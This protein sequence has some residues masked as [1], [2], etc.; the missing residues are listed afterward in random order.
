MVLVSVVRHRSCGF[1]VR[2]TGA[3]LPTVPAFRIAV[4][5]SG[6]SAVRVTG[7]RYCRCTAEN[8]RVDVVLMVTGGVGMAAVISWCDVEAVNIEAANVEAVNAEAV[9]VSL[10]CS[11]PPPP[12]RGDRDFLSPLI[13]I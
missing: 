3:G 5:S 1:T 6:F 12:R 10:P 2:R 13:E 9:T 11:P 8:L 7:C 4:S